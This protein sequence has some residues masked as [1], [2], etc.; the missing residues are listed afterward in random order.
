MDP[1]AIL[2]KPITSLKLR[3]CACRE[4]VWPT[5]FWSRYF[6]TTFAGDDKPVIL[7]V[8]FEISIGLKLFE[9]KVSFTK[10][11]TASLILLALLNAVSI[12]FLENQEQFLVFVN[13]Y[14]QIRQARFHCCQFCL[15][16]QMYF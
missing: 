7:L 10:E 3:W 5:N 2:E 15:I 8:W 9:L 16:P 12:T 1:A 14:V 13:H 11:S 4:Q 6:I